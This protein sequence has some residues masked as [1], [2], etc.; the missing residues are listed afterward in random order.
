MKSIK[1]SFFYKNKRSFLL[2]EILIAIALITL[3][4]I[5][6]I[7]NPIYYYKSQIHSL[8]KIECE[9]LADLSFLEIKISLY[10]NNPSWEEIGSNLKE[11]KV[12]SLDSYTL[13]FSKDLKKK[14]IL[15]SYKIYAKEK[16]TEKNESY[17]LITVEISLKPINRNI[18]Y[19]YKYQLVAKKTH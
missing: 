6:L 9:R 2:I 1:R 4:S 18:S 19:D 12:R 3:I 17:K 15:R 16:K 8:E 7:K 10:N 11:A 5:P 14:E 13:K